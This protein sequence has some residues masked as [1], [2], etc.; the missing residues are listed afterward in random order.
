MV[1]AHPR[2]GDGLARRGLARTTA[3]VEALEQCVSGTVPFPP[4]PNR[5]PIRSLVARLWSA[6]RLTDTSPGEGDE[7]RVRCRR[8]RDRH[9]VVA[10]GRL[11]THT[12][13]ELAEAL[14]DALEGDAAQIVLDLGGLASID[15]AGLDTVLTAHL[16]A[17]DQWR[18][19]V[20]IP[21]PDPVQ[22]VFDDAQAPFLYASAR[23]AGITGRARTRGRRAW[24]L[25]PSGPPPTGPQS[26]RHAP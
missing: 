20:I 2:Y 17:S 26:R 23:R 25:R 21:G 19:L 1:A 14:E 9:I 5:R 13:Y 12:R 4:P 11:N 7:L 24:P 15:H 3:I 22:R 6:W 18:A 10:S 8:S 16:R